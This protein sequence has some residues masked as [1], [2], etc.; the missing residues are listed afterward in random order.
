[1]FIHIFNIINFIWNE[2]QTGKNETSDPNKKLAIENAKKRF[3]DLKDYVNKAEII[4]DIKDENE[5][6]NKFIKA[7]QEFEERK[8][9]DIKKE[10]NKP[11]R[12][13]GNPIFQNVKYGNKLQIFNKQKNNIPALGDE[14]NNSDK[15]TDIEKD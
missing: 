11:T 9:N 3:A 15:D 6:V 12:L 1:M 4:N 7:V 14:I 2:N 5:I 8:K 13:Y 10:K